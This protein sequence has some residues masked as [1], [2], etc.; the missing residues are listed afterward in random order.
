[1]GADVATFCN[2]QANASKGTF[3][4]WCTRRCR[5]ATE[6]DLRPPTT[7]VSSE[8]SIQLACSVL[9]MRAGECRISSKKGPPRRVVATAWSSRVTFV[10]SECDA[11][12]L[13]DETWVALFPWLDEYESAD[14]AQL[15]AL[16]PSVSDWWIADSPRDTAA[17]VALDALIVEL[18]RLA[19]RRHRE[20]AFG[21]LAPCL[22]P[23][24][25]LAGLRLVPRAETVV[26]R[27]GDRALVQTLLL[28]SAESLFALKGTGPD[29]VREVVTGVLGASVLVSPEDGVLPDEDTQ[30]PVAEQLIDD[31]RVLARWRGL[32]GSLGL[33][34]LDIDI[35][36]GAPEEIQ[37][38][39]TR[40]SAINGKDFAESVQS[41]P[42]DELENLIEQ[43]DER[44]MLALT[45]YV[46]A[47]EPISIGQLSVRLHVSKG[48]A[49][50]IV[51]KLK[52]QLAAA[53]AFETTAGGLL[54]SIRAEIQPVTSLERLLDMQP[55]L[56]TEVSS[57]GVPL[58]LALDRLDDGFEVTGSWAVAPDL[59]SAKG[60]TIV[61]LEQ[62]E[63]A[64]A[65]VSMES[66]AMTLKLSTDEVRGWLQYC[67][68]P[69]LDDSVLL[70]TRRLVDHAAGIL[71]VVGPVDIDRL[72][73]LLDT[74]RTEHHVAKCLGND[75]RFAR[76]ATG[77]WC[78]SD[79][80][81]A[82]PP[83]SAAPGSAQSMPAEAIGDL[84]RPGAR[85]QALD[86]AEALGIRPTRRLY[87]IGDTWSFR[88]RVTSEHLRGS[89]FTVPVGVAQV[90][91]CAQ[92]VVREL[93]SRL[94]TQMVRWTGTNPTCGT[95]RRFLAELSS[96]I[97][98]WVF[99]TYSDARGFDVA[100]CAEVE[101]ANP[102]CRALA[103]IGV[104]DPQG[105]ADAK[106][107]PV[108]AMAIGLDPDT[109][110]R[111]ILSRYQARDDA[112]ASLLEEAWTVGLR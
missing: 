25:P 53:C 31:L 112:V 77:L 84:G 46:M 88:L 85:S 22:D 93:P 107:A 50:G 35:E 15:E 37:E 26:R 67:E 32:R 92:G 45:E 101:A 83:E 14:A 23:S 20:V 52:Q 71:E 75:E 66:A 63:S 103:L 55:L 91:G 106:V 41:N 13:R 34:L 111:R 89:G 47:A 94:G 68:I 43:L 29:T 16:V 72:T 78:L 3:V 100:S 27:L 64:N 36:D 6:S 42:V 1:M 108:L 59:R 96:Q 9:G 38:I 79:S 40:I 90:L 5:V 95:I 2:S 54:A 99:L 8:R 49:S 51:A 39:A 58:W 24:I 74:D 70:S 4:S 21:E 87:R 65:V 110:P 33:P 69:I 7:F 104:G 82:G 11:A 17:D 48:R 81:A 44:E 73:D 76:T 18:A 98:D 30:S 28:T 97:G 10:F 105:V 80:V 86:P 19:V 57:L 62:F 109:K 56:R 102:V 12:E 61:M 60:R